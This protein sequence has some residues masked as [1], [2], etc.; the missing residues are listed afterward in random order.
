MYKPSFIIFLTAISFFIICSCTPR[1]VSNE[2]IFS[3][4]TKQKDTTKI[5]Q[6]EVETIYENN[7]NISK[8]KKESTL[9]NEKILSE[10]EVILPSK[11]NI[12]ITKAFIN[13]L[14]LSI[15]KKNIDNLSFN[16]NTYVD[17][18]NLNKIIKSKVKAGKIFIGPLTSS[19]SKEIN[20]YCE[21][22]VIFLSFASDRQLASDCVYL[23]NF[24]PEDD[25]ITLFN[26]FNSQARI[27]LL[28]PENNYGFYINNII[29]NISNNSKAIL[30]NKSSYKEDLSNARDAIKQLGKYE[31]RRQE[32]E[33]QKKILKDKNDEIS[34]R[35]L[36]KIEKFETIGSLDFTHVIIADHNIRL[37]KI[38]PLL[39]FYD[40]DP[41]KIKFVG[42]GVWDNDVF[43]DEP[44]LQ[45]A[46]F[47]G[48]NKEKRK[49]FIQEYINSYNIEPIRTSTIMYDLVGLLSYI[50]NNKLTLEKTF[51]LLNDQKLSFEGIDGKF[52]FNQNLI[53]RDLKILQIKNGRALPIN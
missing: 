35:A 8:K 49:D 31:I 42:T 10:I 50:I 48:V 9:N 33:R 29:E 39:P 45:E 47:P 37:L 28:Y 6:K 2:G 14:E 51:I 30:V 22:G 36:K 5:N 12:E 15:Y 44:S 13:S 18:K 52:S 20:Q 46:I 25:L 26:H 38:V 3:K 43:F 41:N 4:Q 11:E 7:N 32:L 17:K 24:F 27:A 53:K 23:I 16:I 1:F 21:L 40:I 19:D 34:K